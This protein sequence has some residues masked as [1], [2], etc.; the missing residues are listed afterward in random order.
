MLH[1][2]ANKGQKELSMYFPHNLP[3]KKIVLKMMLL[4]YRNFDT[5]INHNDLQNHL[6]SCQTKQ[7]V[8]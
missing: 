2:L 8:H 4:L 1:W 3:P 7:Q 5:G 6:N